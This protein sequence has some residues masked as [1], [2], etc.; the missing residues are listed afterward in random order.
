MSTIPTDRIGLTLHSE[1]PRWDLSHEEILSH[2]LVRTR[3]GWSVVARVI[4]T[5]VIDG[6][7]WATTRH[8]RIP[9]TEAQPREDSHGQA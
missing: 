1:S 9:L 3:C 8:V 4:V 5:V 2:T 7:E 6:R